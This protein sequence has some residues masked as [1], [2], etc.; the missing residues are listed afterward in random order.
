MLNRLADLVRLRT[1]ANTLVQPASRVS[2]EALQEFPLGGE[3]RGQVKAALPDGTFQVAI[4][5][6]SFVLRLPFPAQAGD[7]LQLYVAAREP[8]LRF[9]VGVP[10]ES[11]TSAASLSE[12]A[13]F[14]TA[15]LSEAA[16]LP[17]TD[18]AH[19]GTPL[20]ATPPGNHDEITAGLRHALT[21]SGMFYESHQA[22]WAAGQRPLTLLLEEPQAQLPPLTAAQS[23]AADA[24]ID[25]RS[26]DS[27]G[28]APH[29]SDLPRLPELP[30]HRDTLNIVRHQLLTLDT[31]QI[32][33]NGLIWHDQPVEWEVTRHGAGAPDAPDAPAEQPWRTRLTMTLPR[34]GAIDASLLITAGGVTVM[35][36]AASANA[37]ATLDEHKAELRQALR[38][39]G[40]TPL[41]ITVHRDETV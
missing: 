17:L 22:Q 24:H 1:Y 40:V 26:A 30:V 34:L 4:G 37:A 32:V 5:K 36:H 39:V 15:L 20:L 13:R 14:I 29:P 31:Q 38:G 27:A 11:P 21:A 7:V 9:A 10:N 6:Q 3:L 2:L 19:A 35:L 8:Q 25:E 18:V 23:S 12:T 16:K 28:A 33:W 41:S